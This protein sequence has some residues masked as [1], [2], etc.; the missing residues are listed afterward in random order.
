MNEINVIERRLVPEK[1]KVIAKEQIEIYVPVASYTN[2]GV[3]AYNAS[4]FVLDGDVVKLK[5]N[6]EY[7]SSRIPTTAD[8]KIDDSYRLNLVL[9]NYDGKIVISD[10]VDLKLKQ[11][12]SNNATMIA[13]NA[14]DIQ[15]LRN[16]F[17]NEEHF[18]GWVTKNSGFE[19]LKGDTN[20]FAYSAESGTVW[21]YNDD[22]GWEDSGE[23]IPGDGGSGV[24]S[25]DTPLMDGTATAGVS[26][27]YARGDHRHPSDNNK[28]DKI[29]TATGLV[30][31]YIIDANGVQS[32][33]NIATGDSATQPGRLVY[34]RSAA[35]TGITEP[36]ATIAVQTPV[37]PYAAAN[38]KYVD[39]NFVAKNAPKGTAVKLY[40]ETSEGSV[41]HRLVN[42]AATPTQGTIPIYR[43]NGTLSAGIPTELYH[44]TN[45]EYVDTNFVGK[46]E[47]A[48]ATT[49]GVVKG[50]KTFGFQVNANGIATCDI[51]TAS[52]YTDKT[53]ACFISKGTLEN[54]KNAIVKSAIVGNDITLTD[55]EKAAAQAWLGISGNSGSSSADLSDYVKKTAFNSSYGMKIS[56]GYVMLNAAT[57]SDITTGTNSYKGITPNRVDFL[58][59]KGITASKLTLSD[60]E[61]TKAQEWLGISGGGGTSLYMH[62]LTF[63]RRDDDLDRRVINVVTNSADA[64]TIYN[65]E[66][67]PQEYVCGAY[68]DSVNAAH[69]LSKIYAYNSLGFFAEYIQSNG[70]VETK[71]FDF[72]DTY[73]MYDEII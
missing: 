2:A 8:L 29:T 49:A 58:V 5:Y 25:N 42:T 47:Y 71:S 60:A 59:K 32:T 35:A 65:I 38:K 28:I 22:I 3:A 6:E 62:R 15:G 51:L 13:Q 27:A 40:G 11:V 19:T 9:Y 37:N 14:S 34:L 56:N 54:A 67:L 21:I 39:D 30:R 41:V 55:D 68:I 57:E 50:D 36:T 72:V 4:D 64:Y 17:K 16:D 1:P 33:Y 12:L 18:R 31:A 45:K 69:T 44:A 66:N 24:A 10:T 73:D 70:T 7:Y 20:D 61:K 43:E 63:V 52:E 23:K 48:T 46:T 53:V 26:D